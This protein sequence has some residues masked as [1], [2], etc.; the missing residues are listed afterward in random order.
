M[1]EPE[2][3]QKIL[4]RA[5][6]ASRRAAERLI[7]EGRVRVNGKVADAL[8]TKAI[9]GRDSITVDGR[10]LGLPEPPAYYMF[11]KPEGF[12]TALSDGKLKRPTIAG[13]LEAIPYRVYPVGR[14]DRDVSG[15]LVLTNDGELS[16][17]LMHPSFC[18]PK[19]YRAIVE[20]HPS[21][22]AIQALTDGSLII[23]GKPA[24]RASARMLKSGDDRGWLEL[25]LT[26]G[27]HRQVKKMCSQIGHPVEKLKRVAY[28]GI[29]LDPRLP[30]GAFR[31]LSP[32]EVAM[33]KDAVGLPTGK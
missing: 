33:L 22:R 12:L 18:A 9:P 23:D 26:E 10:E 25:V 32:G 27:R 1:Q 20:G 21:G 31:E 19:V 11:N 8:G 28:A 5:G 15:F 6:V 30:P 17:R 2:R 16:R 29:K 7:L 3:L 14:L 13:F 24:K 4:A